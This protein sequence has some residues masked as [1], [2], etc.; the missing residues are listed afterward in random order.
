[1]T[2]L[3]QRGLAATIAPWFAPTFLLYLFGQLVSWT[4]SRINAVALPLLTIERYGIGLSLGLVA[5]TRLV[6]GVLLGPSVGQL[7]DRLPRRATIVASNLVSAGLVAL[8]PLTSE[9]WQLYALAALVGLAEAPLRAAGFAIL[10]ELFPREALYRVNAAREVLDALSNLLGPTIAAATIAAFGIGWAF[11]ADSGSFVIAA[12]CFL[13]L[14]R[15]PASAVAGERDVRERAAGG[16]FRVAWRLFRA[17]SDLAWLFAINAGYTLGIGFLLILYAPLAFRLG[18]G[19]WGF[20]A[21]VTATGAGALLGTVVAPRLGPF[22]TPRRALIGLACSGLLLVAGGLTAVFPLLL[23]LLLLAH[24]PE[25]LCYLI[26]A[27]ESQRRVAPAFLGRYYGVA[28][29]A[30]AAALPLGNFLGGAL[31][32]RYDP[33]LGLGLVGV[34]FVAMACLGL[35]RLAG[36]AT[37][38]GGV[39]IRP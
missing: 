31:V 32:S 15:L 12:L 38:P 18:V 25:S 3:S 19:E 9:L 21:I 6:P 24:A 11:W 23:A 36:S 13:V 27:T 26:F 2:L 34:G 22:F 17:E 14:R 30:L 5:A 33:R 1:M 35:L 29:T 37:K 20:G 10:P 39:S 7:V 28:M 8:I 4:G 16:A